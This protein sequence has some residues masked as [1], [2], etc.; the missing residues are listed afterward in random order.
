MKT[1]DL[2]KLASRHSATQPKLSLKGFI[3]EF[4]G[5]GHQQFRRICT[6]ER[7]ASKETLARFNTAHLRLFPSEPVTLLLPNQPP[8]ILGHNPEAN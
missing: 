6:G 2:P 3:H 1:L 5:I 8:V 7:G 4:Y